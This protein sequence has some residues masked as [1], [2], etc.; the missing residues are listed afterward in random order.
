MKFTVSREQL[1][2]PL[3]LVAGA[4]ERRQTM[5]IL[6]NLLIRVSGDVLYITGTDL[7]VELSA[8]IT[9]I[10]KADSD[11]DITIPARKFVD[12][13]K[14]LPDGCDISFELDAGKAI[15]KS[16]RSRYSL[17]TLPATDF[18]SVQRDDS[19]FSV[20]VNQADFARLLSRT[21]FSMAQQDV[22]YYLNGMLWELTDRTF[23]SVATD[24]HRLAI[25]HIDLAE[26]IEADKQQFIIP[27]KGVVELTRLLADE[28]ANITVEFGANHIRATTEGM[29]FVSKLVDGK[30][31]DYER[32]LP[33][34]GNKLVVAKKEDLKAALSRSAILSNEKFRGIRFTLSDGMVGIQAN[35][36][37][38]E[39]AHEEVSVNYQGDTVEMGFNVS[40]LIEVLGVLGS[41]EVNITLSDSA[42]SALIQDGN[43]DNNALYV[44]MPMR[45]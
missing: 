30:F 15:V 33:K 26:A 31:P 25:A 36:P 32:V 38:Q 22:R 27:R 29:V 11:G 37:E 10:T 28:A 21:S 35:N 41:E 8:T 12:I 40:Y 16:G 18:P 5:P 7:E 39:E 20:T 3:T 1:L 23:K 45:L 42:S 34:G 24:G 9:P 2:R 4:V 43:P 19:G 44:V 14:S 6:A 13:C 17:V